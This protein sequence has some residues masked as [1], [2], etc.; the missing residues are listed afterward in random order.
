MLPLAAVVL[1]T[2]VTRI[3]LSAM[4]ILSAVISSIDL[5]RLAAICADIHPLQA[6]E[7]RANHV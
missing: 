6:V 2:S 5:P 1:L 4:L 7:R 3:F